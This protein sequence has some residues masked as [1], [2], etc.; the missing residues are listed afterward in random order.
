[1]MAEIYTNTLKGAPR[2]E[3]LPLGLKQKRVRIIFCVSFQHQSAVLVVSCTF[4]VATTTKPTPLQNM[5][6]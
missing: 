1:M 4:Q 5:K 2:A 6:G 3:R